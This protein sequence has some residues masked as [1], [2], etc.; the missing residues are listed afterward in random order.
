MSH[1][2]ITFGAGFD[3]RLHFFAVDGGASFYSLPNA[4][5]LRVL[6]GDASASTIY[7]VI[8]Y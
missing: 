3:V 7:Y 4:N 8:A 5:T 6:I 1:D 2:D